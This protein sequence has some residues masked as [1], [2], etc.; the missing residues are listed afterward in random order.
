MAKNDAIL[1][2]GIIEQRVKES[3]P[4]ARMDEVFEYLA[5]EQVLKDYD[6]SK[7]E[8]E[9][10]WVDGRDDGGI[11]GF[12]TF[13]NGHLVRDPGNF[14]WPRRN[15]EI[16]VWILT[17]KHHDTFKQA[18]LNA[19]HAS[20]SELFDFSL[21]A[22]EMKGSYSDELL[23]A[24]GLFFA[25]YKSLSTARP[26]LSINFGYVSRGDTSAVGEDVAARAAQVA[27]LTRSLFSSSNS[28]F[29]FV[30]AAEL[31]A[32]YRRTKKFSI[33]LPVLEYLSRGQSGYIVLAGLE[34]YGRFVTDEKGNLRR[35][36]F[37]SNVRDFLGDT[38]VNEDIQESLLFE[39]GADFWWLNNG[40]TI[41]ATAATVVGRT[42]Q[43]EDIQI[44]NGLQTTESIFNHFKAGGRS[45]SGRGLLIKV[46]VSTE[47]PHRDRI[48]R[49]TNNQNPVEIAGLRATDK[50]QLAIEEY[51]DRHDWFYERRKNY[52]RNIG[53]P[54]ARFVTP[55]YLATG[56]AALVLKNPAGAAG[57]KSGFMRNDDSYGM[58]FSEKTP[59]PVWLAIVEI[60]KR[61]EG[62]LDPIRPIAGGG[63]R[64]LA[65]WR[66]L[67][68]L[69]AISKCLGRFS[70]GV[71][72]LLDFDINLITPLL[73]KEIWELVVSQT[74]LGYKA[75]VRRGESFATT[76]CYIAASLFDID[77]VQV[78]GKHPVPHNKPAKQKRVRTQEE[79]EVK[80]NLTESFL[81][82]VNAALPVQPWKPGTSRMVAEK[83]G[84][85]RQHVHVAIGVLIRQGRRNEQ[86][87]GVVYGVNGEVLAIDEERRP[88]MTK[89][90]DIDP[91]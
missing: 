90:K 16:Q 28:K 15:A 41:L 53:K 23:E 17:C 48:I 60:L 65:K 54:P 70:Y 66:G 8:I 42:L 29:D 9:S 36:L 85:S 39:D 27:E 14:P 57:L 4:S 81:D 51:L 80:L 62:Y 78:V 73:L 69:L 30:G 55:M 88:D 68:S 74:K 86:R 5:F 12:F 26:T 50:L 89:P 13:V 31:V 25:A 35:Y 40:V 64:F 44:V 58:I 37:D 77:D 43:L 34:E 72:D 46:V 82:E 3:L 45:S 56:F 24:R 87:D 61:T 59:L 10:G 1:I 91:Y 38:Q 47:Q 18:P 83:L 32:L 20:V 7:E 21:D 6:L 63:E 2:D 67:V 76:C 22:G 52:F 79:L 11:D 71:V 33:S 75:K 19:L 49:A 84:C